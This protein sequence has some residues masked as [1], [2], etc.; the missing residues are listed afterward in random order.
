M[1]RVNEC[2]ENKK[3]ASWSADYE[4]A[5]LLDHEVATTVTFF[6]RLFFFKDARMYFSCMSLFLTLGRDG[7]W[8]RPWLMI[9]TKGK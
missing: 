3:A 1:A 9:W 5:V 8:V 7:E 4:L 2:E 6:L